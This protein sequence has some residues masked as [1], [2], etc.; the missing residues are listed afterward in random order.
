MSPKLVVVGAGHAHL[1][2]LKELHSLAAAGAETVVVN[3]G[4]YHYYSGMG[5]GALSGVYRPEEIR[6]DVRKLTEDRGGRFITGRV[7]RIDPAERRVVLKSGKTLPYDVLSVNTGST[8]APLERAPVNGARVIPVKPIENLIRLRRWILSAGCPNPVRICVAGGGPAG[9]ET[10]ANLKAL[11]RVLPGSVEVTLISAAPVLDSFPGAV[12]RRVLNRFSRM[13][14]ALA[15]DARAIGFGNGVVELDTGE[16]LPADL[17]VLATGT[18]A[19][20]LFGRSGLPLGSDGGLLVNSRLQSV[21]YPEIFGGGDCIS[22]GPRPLERVG[23]HAVRQNPVLK[24]NVLAALTGGKLMEYVPPKRYLLIL[25]MGGGAGI[26]N[27]GW[28]TF[29]G[30][31]AFMVKDFIDRRFMKTFQVS[32]ETENQT[33]RMK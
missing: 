4:P 26:L 33:D 20:G 8:I 18:R 28:M 12:R 15:E 10:A 11:E 2:L 24:A 32:G 3:T 23:V 21:A 29:D 19:P 6:F 1:T 16:Q 9:V 31:A 14:I 5:P 30:K 7:I 27:R 13:K 25:N 17:L 22:F